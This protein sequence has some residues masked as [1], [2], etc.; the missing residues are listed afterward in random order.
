VRCLN[1][2]FRIHRSGLWLATAVGLILLSSL[3]TSW[4]VGQAATRT[5]SSFPR[6]SS[7]A[8]AARG[9]DRL[10]EAVVLY[11]KALTVRPQWAE[12][13]W[14][15]GTIYYDRNS[16]PQA[17]RAFATLVRL[18]PTDGTAYV[19]LGLTEFELGKMTS[20]SGT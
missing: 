6:L 16:Y 14:S 18:K 9:A 17:A 8:D 5:D 15:L 20:R 4:A 3:A 10:D 12:G 7:Q 2:I 19:M 1:W 13:W 11:K